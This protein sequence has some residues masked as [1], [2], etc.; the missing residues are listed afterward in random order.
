MGEGVVVVSRPQNIR[1]LSQNLPFMRYE[2]MGRFPQICTMRYSVTL[3][4]QK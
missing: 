2:Y 3:K 4:Y 1:K